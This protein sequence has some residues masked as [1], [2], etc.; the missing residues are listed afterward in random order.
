MS[1]HGDEKSRSGGG[2]FRK[3]LYSSGHAVVDVDH[4]ANNADARD[5]HQEQILVA[6]RGRSLPR[7]VRWNIE[8]RGGN[9]GGA[10]EHGFGEEKGEIGKRGGRRRIVSSYLVLVTR[11]SQMAEKLLP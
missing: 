9:K 1:A 8:S 11:R 4:V 6:I 5:Q 10:K 7:R 2:V 3:V